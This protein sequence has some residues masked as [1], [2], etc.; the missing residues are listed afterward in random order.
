[1]SELYTIEAEKYC[2][3]VRDGTHD[4]PKQ[5]DPN[6]KTLAKIFA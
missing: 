6:S 1:M 2:A 3:S 5:V 4:T